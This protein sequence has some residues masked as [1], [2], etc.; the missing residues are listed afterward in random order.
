ML[1]EKNKIYYIVDNLKELKETENY[2]GKEK[3]LEIVNVS[4][5]TMITKTF[6]PYVIV[7]ASE[8][9]VFTNMNGVIKEIVEHKEEEK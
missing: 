7:K 6:K 5:F 2:E 3:E 1:T 4:E 8:G 9:R